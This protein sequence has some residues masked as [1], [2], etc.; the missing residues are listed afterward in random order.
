M[1]L[2]SRAFVAVLS[3]ATI[4]VATAGAPAWSSETA[5][6][7]FAQKEG[8]LD[9]NDT[10][11]SGVTLCVLPDKN[12][13]FEMPSS[14]IP[15]DAKD[16]YQFALNPRSER[17]PLAGGGS[18]VFFSG[19]FSGGGSGMLERVA[20]LRHAAD[21]RI[22]NLMPEVTATDIADRAMWNVPEVSPYPVFIRADFIWGDGEDHF[23]QHVFGVDGWTFD[24]GVHQY[25]KVFSY[26]TV[27]RYARG[28]QDDH[29]LKAEREEIL[30]RLKAGR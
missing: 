18:W 4:V 10:P 24:P 21:G 2:L 19:M 13:C 1:K 7:R 9:A 28:D 16:R 25:R 11:L 15:G 27:R 26:R 17:L 5:F 8:R 30:R 23:G 20:V 29:V 14:P 3:V 6:P 22:E 12:P